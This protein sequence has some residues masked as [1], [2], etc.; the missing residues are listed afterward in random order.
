MDDD[1]ALGAMPGSRQG[2]SPEPIR[3][4]EVLTGIGRRQTFGLDQKLAL[5]ARMK[6]CANISALAR[7]HDLRPAQ[8]FTWRRQ[9]RYAAEV[10]G[11]RVAPKPPMFV[12]AVIEPTVMSAPQPRS[13][14]QRRK[15]RTASTVVELEIDGVAVR[16]A[17]GADGAM[18]AAVIDAL[19]PK[20]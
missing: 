7:E 6:G 20:G 2:V 8:L 3:R 14:G 9:L 11:K 5:V 12:P 17:R 13:A 15:R 18:I 1:D 4:F 19:K 10:A 16:I